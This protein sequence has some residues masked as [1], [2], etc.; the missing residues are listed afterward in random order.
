MLGEGCAPCAF[1]LPRGVAGGPRLYRYGVAAPSAA[2]GWALAS[3]QPGDLLACPAWPWGGPGA[4]Y[5]VSR[6]ASTVLAGR[7]PH[8]QALWTCAPGRGPALGQRR[9]LGWHPRGTDRRAA[10]GGIGPA[11]REGGALFGRSIPGLSVG[12]IPAAG[13]PGAGAV[14]CRVGND[15]AVPGVCGDGGGAARQPSLGRSPV[16][17]GGERRADRLEGGAR[18][19]AQRR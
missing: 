10:R 11:G 12:I 8:P 16:V 15:A 14:V 18:C 5:R 7:L 1:W 13:G 3:P 6:R 2:S 4:R 17:S 9:G 19:P